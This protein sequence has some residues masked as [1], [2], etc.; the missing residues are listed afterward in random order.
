MMKKLILSIA[1]L[2]G[3]SSVWL[4]WFS[5]VHASHSDR[6]VARAVESFVSNWERKN[7]KPLLE[8]VQ[9][10][11]PA[12]KDRVSDN[13]HLTE[14]LNQIEKAINDKLS[15]CVSKDVAQWFASSN[16]AT[17]TNIRSIE[18]DE[19]LSWWPPKDGIPALNE[20]K[21]IDINTANNG[22]YLTSTSEWVAV[23]NNGT[24]KFYPY[25]VLNRHEIVNDTI[26]D[27]N[28]AITFCP[29]CGTAITFS[30]EF[31]GKVVNFWVSGRLYNSNLL[32]Y[33]DHTESL[34]SQA[35][36]KGVVGFYTDYQLEYVDS[37][38]MTYGEFVDQYP[39]G[40]VL[41]DDTGHD[42]NYKIDSPYG[43][44]DNNDDLYF[45]VENLDSS[46]PKKTMLYIA[47]DTE[48]ERS[49]WFIQEDLVETWSARIDAD[50]VNYNALYSN[51]KVTI[52][53]ESDG[54]Q[55]WTFTQMRFSWTAHE[56][57]PRYL[58]EG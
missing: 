3:I 4:L 11:L 8:K 13:A 24:S 6:A 33:D 57:Y 48:T 52:T 38:V 16:L 55:I 10:V 50:G 37:D 17:N 36:G 23:S 30:R 41:S 32:M 7:R 58:W 21:F 46:L 14:I 44:Y 9:R 2:F 43:D 54:T 25:Q 26:G 42:R 56:N 49:L 34:W 45:P 22:G 35:I 1:M 47:N 51:G 31:D 18:L 20:P 39:S 40:M 19:V 27:Q 29:L 15:I 28:I 53:R 5:C 12:A